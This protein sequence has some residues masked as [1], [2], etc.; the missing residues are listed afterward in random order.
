M[1]QWLEN[2]ILNTGKNLDVS[3]FNLHKNEQFT[4]LLLKLRQVELQ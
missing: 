1:S 2:V 4:F 3:L